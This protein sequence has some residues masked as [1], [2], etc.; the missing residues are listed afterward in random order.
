MVFFA[1]I[2]FIVRSVVITETISV[3]DTNRTNV[4]ASKPT[5][6]LK[7][8]SSQASISKYPKLPK[9]VECMTEKTNNPC[10]A[11]N[12]IRYLKEIHK[13]L[14]YNSAHCEACNRNKTIKQIDRRKIMNHYKYKMLSGKLCILAANNKCARSKQIVNWIIICKLKL[15]SMKNCNLHSS[16]IR[17]EKKKHAIEM[18]VLSFLSN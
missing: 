11:S 6:F 3:A 9:D 12:Y 5:S 1:F 13:K 7:H 14:L 16:I 10:L 2:Q 18:N 4:I 17:D 8:Q 15:N